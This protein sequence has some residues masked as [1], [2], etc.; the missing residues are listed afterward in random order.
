MGVGSLVCARTF[1]LCLCCVCVCARVCVRVCV[2][3]CV[4][5]C[6]CACALETEITCRHVNK[7]NSVRLFGLFN[8]G[9]R[10]RLVLLER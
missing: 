3:V 7:T 8:K 2:C 4:C 9:T 10:Y 6:V 5:A 1:V